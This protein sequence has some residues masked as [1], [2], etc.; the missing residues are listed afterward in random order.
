MTFERIPRG[1][2]VRT[3][4]SDGAFAVFM[5]RRP[6]DAHMRDES[7]FAYVDERLGKRYAIEGTPADLLRA[8]VEEPV[9]GAIELLEP[10]R[11][12]IRGGT[13]WI[14]KL[15]ESDDF[16]QPED[17]R[18]AHDLARALADKVRSLRS[19]PASPPKP[20]SPTT[21]NQPDDPYRQLALVPVQREEPRAPAAKEPG[22]GALVE[23]T[24][25]HR[26][27]IEAAFG[28]ALTVGGV[29]WSACP[30]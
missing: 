27:R 9:R 22:S 5:Q 26:S 11:M 30:L 12:S 13:V 29:L 24:P 16:A 4:T 20:P 15:Y 19:Q 21:E 25:R 23:A 2:Q 10:D 8:V 28:V 18:R 14:Q 7:K 17:I 1:W 6:L 3:R